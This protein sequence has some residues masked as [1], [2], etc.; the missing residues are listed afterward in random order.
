MVLFDG[1]L[2]DIPCMFRKTRDEYYVWDARGGTGET[3]G[4]LNVKTS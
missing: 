4:G 3:G 2:T 1:V